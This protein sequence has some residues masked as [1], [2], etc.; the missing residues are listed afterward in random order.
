V[1]YLIKVTDVAKQMIKEISDRRIR[2]EIAKRVDKLADD[3][4]LQGKPLQGI[5]AGYRSVRAVGQRYRIIYKIH[6]KNLIVYIIGAGIRKEGGKD[7]IYTRLQKL[8][9]KGFDIN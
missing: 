7:D 9:M 5:L 3:P 4:N 1:K 8:L 2:G 6:E